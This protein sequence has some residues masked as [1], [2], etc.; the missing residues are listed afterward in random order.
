MGSSQS[1]NQPVVLAAESSKAQLA[2]LLCGSPDLR[3]V[4]R[5]DGA[6]IRKLWQACDRALTEEAYGAF[7]PET[8][9]ILFECHQCG[10]RFFDPRLAGSGRFYEELEHAGYYVAE[11]PEF[12][13][14][15]NLCRQENIRKLLDVG[16]GE[17]AFLDLAKAAGLET[18]GLELNQQAAELSA[19]K[20]HRMLSRPLEELSAQDLGG[21]VDMLT[22]FQVVEHVPD[23]KSF[24][25]AAAVLVRPGGLIVVAVPNRF[26]LRRVQPLDPA[27]LPPHH[28][29]HWRMKD[30]KHLGEVSGLQWHSQGA[31]VLFG[32]DIKAFWLAHNRQC[33]A[34]GCPPRFGGAWFPNLVSLLYRK[35]AC[36]YY[37]PRWGLSIY[38]AYRKI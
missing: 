12:R 31:D 11:R 34:I 9:V 8:E 17:G 36:R 38:A 16:G 18:Y 15:L 5:F 35:L 21:P 2:C 20:G 4:L 29:S 14:A 28:V 6:M 37:S 32:G 3:H 27:N 19:G 22:L 24:L 26:G 1:V 25:K 30:L 33:R 13:F 10:F 7:R 23:P